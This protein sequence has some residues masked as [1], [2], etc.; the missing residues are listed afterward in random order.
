MSGTS[1]RASCNQS[2]ASMLKACSRNR[3][4]K[5]PGISERSYAYCKNGRHPDSLGRQTRMI[6]S[7]MRV[8]CYDKHARARGHEEC[9]NVFKLRRQGVRA[10]LRSVCALSAVLRWRARRSS[11]H[12]RW[13]N[14]NTATLYTLW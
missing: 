11:L 7:F 9:R 12:A 10:C 2:A 3:H 6:K 14:S 4:T 13:P 1:P 5:R 8:K